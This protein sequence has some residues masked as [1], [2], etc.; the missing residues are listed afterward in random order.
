MFVKQVANE[1]NNFVVNVGP[2]TE[3]RVPK[4]PNILPENFLKNRNSIQL[5]QMKVYWE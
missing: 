4:L 1:V 2:I 5:S 3:N